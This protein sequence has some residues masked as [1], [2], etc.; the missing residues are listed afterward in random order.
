MFL[1]STQ[2]LIPRGRG[3][4]PASHIPTPAWEAA[5]EWLGVGGCLPGDLP[6]TLPGSEDSTRLL[7]TELLTRELPSPEPCVP[8]PAFLPQGE[9]LE[10]W[11]AL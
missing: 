5:R 11:R 6:L 2:Q 1:A 9:G 4:V 7:R 8:V 10:R 3:P